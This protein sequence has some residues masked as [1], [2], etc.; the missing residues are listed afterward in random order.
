MSE[1]KSAGQTRIVRDS[2]GEMEVPAQ[3]LWGAQTQRSLQNF[4]IGTEKMPWQQIRAML[5]IKA[6]AAAVNGAAGRL[7]ATMAA[8]IQAV[9]HELIAEADTAH[10]PLSVWQTG[11]GTQSNMNVNEVVAE[12]TSRRMAGVHPNDHVNKSQSSNDVFPAAMHIAARRLL[13]EEVIPA[14]QELIAGFLALEER[15]GAVI[16]IGRTHLQDAV[17]LRFAQ[18]VSG[19][20]SV[21]EQDSELIQEAAEHLAVLPLGGTAVG[22]GLNTFEGYKEEVA[23]ELSLITGMEFRPVANTFSQLGGK[24]YI[25]QAHGSLRILAADLFKIA[26]DIRLLASGPRCGLAEI[27]LPANEPGSSIMPGKVN[28]TQCEALCMLCTQVM[29]N[30]S[31]MSFA[32]A[33]GHLQL[34]T[35]MPLMIYN[36]VQSATLLA[37]GCRSFQQRCVAGIK[38][39]ADHMQ[40]NVERSLMLVTKLAPEIGYEAC[41]AAVHTAFAEDR[42][43]KETVLSAGLL[44][45]EDYDRLMKLDDMLGPEAR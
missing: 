34:N 6:A 14:V 45:A 36:F 26:N 37:D 4:P 27:E 16:K 44:S 40:E 15:S 5:E 1:E 17:P 33:S 12:L 31:T 43:L 24:N 7:D 13:I 39:N 25:L 28:P 21:L 8:H 30:D 41:A 3:E 22:T 35:F 38:V 19:W 9:C 11:S 2:M 20:R 42:T 23:A 18:E 10:F 32:G 29:G